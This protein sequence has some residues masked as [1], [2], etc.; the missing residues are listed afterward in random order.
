MS[1]FTLNHLQF[2]E[3]EAIH[4]LRET[5]AQFER[6][7]LLYSVGKDSSVI[8]RLAQKAFYPSKIPFPLMHVDT[9]F[10]FPEMYE[11]RDVFIKEIGAEL[12]VYRNEPAIAAN[13][14][15]YDFGTQR[16]CSLL[17]TQ[18]LVAALREGK[19][20]AALGGARRE[21][22]RSRA[23]ERIFSFRDKFGQW[24]PKNQRPELWNYYNGKLGPGESMR[25]FPLSNW[26]ELD[27]WHYIH[28]EKIPLVPLYFAKPRL[29]V[30]RGDQLIPVVA[31]LGRSDV[32]SGEQ[33]QEIMCRF[34]TLGCTPC[35][36]AV[37]SQAD[38]VP[39]IIDEMLEASVSERA[40]RVIDHDTDGSMEIKKKEGYF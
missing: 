14:N 12:I 28:V 2:L 36:G 38:T 6:P 5:A 8:V 21:E 10:D 18:A 15:P 32:L 16:C 20:D 34:R 26:T 35:T 19:F 17:R 37:R 3:A 33:P 40:T 13:T 31:S 29:M 23:K 30:E 7:V 24:D 1:S 39:K 27:V 9:G 4:I 25:V 11:F 22:E